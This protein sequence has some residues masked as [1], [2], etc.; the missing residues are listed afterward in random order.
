MP[1]YKQALEVVKKEIDALVDK[2]PSDVRKWVNR[3]DNLLKDI[4]TDKGTATSI[5]SIKQKNSEG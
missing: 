4:L 5:T 2:T 1:D 3:I